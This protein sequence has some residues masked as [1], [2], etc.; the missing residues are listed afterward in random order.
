LS[1]LQ[2]A[3]LLKLMHELAANGAPSDRL[4]ARLVQA[5]LAPVRATTAFHDWRPLQGDALTVLA[6][7][8]HASHDPSGAFRA[9]W[10]QLLLAGSEPALPDDPGIDAL[11]AALDRLVRSTT[12][13]RRRLVDGAAHALSAD[14]QVSANEAELLRLICEA[15]GQPLPLFRSK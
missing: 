12:A 15:L 9:G 1:P 7:L 10:R 2:T 14:G 13:I 8:A 6:T 4:L 3:D 5:Y 11:G